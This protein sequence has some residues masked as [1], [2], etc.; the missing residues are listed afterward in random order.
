MV[1]FLKKLEEKFF[2]L[3][4]IH[5][6]GCGHIWDDLWEVPCAKVTCSTGECEYGV[7]ATRRLPISQFLFRVK[8][9]IK[10]SGE[11]YIKF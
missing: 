3:F 1:K 8:Q 9:W 7:D 11:K 4:G 10:R 2:K 6:G 5:T